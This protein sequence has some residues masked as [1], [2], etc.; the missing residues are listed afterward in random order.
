MSASRPAQRGAGVH[1][2]LLD[3]QRPGPAQ[4]GERVA[5]AAGAVQRERQQ[6]PGVLAPGVL[7][8]VRVQVRHGLGGAAQGQPGLGPAFDGVQAQL[9]QA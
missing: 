1:S 6:P 5:L 2:Q 8:H 4:H 7:G 3:Q 9:G